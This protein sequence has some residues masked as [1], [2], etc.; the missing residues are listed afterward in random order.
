[1]PTRATPLYLQSER[2]LTFHKPTAGVPLVYTYDPQTPVAT[3]GGRELSLPSGPRDQRTVESRPDVLVF[4][5]EPL[6]QP[7]EVVGHV[8]AVLHVASDAPD[9]DFIVRLCDVYP[10]GRSY[11]ITE[12]VLRMRYRESR[13]RERLMQPEQVYRVE[14]DLWTTA[15]VFNTGHRLRVHVTSSSAPGYDPNPNTGDPF[16][17]DTR[18]RPARN[19]V[20]CDA[21]RVSYLLLPIVAR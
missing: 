15:M 16:R 7:L 3:V 21:Q 1:M 6:Q 18:A 9:T 4:T 20:Y 14:V 8:K 17:A 13:S 19:T 11:N 2:T 5:S 12:G 10:D